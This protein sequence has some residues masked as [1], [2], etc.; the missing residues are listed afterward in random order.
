[1]RR[2][3]FRLAL[4]GLVFRRQRGDGVGRVGAGCA[5]GTACGGTGPMVAGGCREAGVSI[6][7]RS[8]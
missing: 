2:Q 3:F 7:V 6:G 5:P 4:F 8:P 1:L